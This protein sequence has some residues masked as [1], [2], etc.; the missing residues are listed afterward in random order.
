M[1]RITMEVEI[2]VSLEYLKEYAD[3]LSALTESV[4]K[5]TQQGNYRAAISALPE[6]EKR[7]AAVETEYR[8]LA[9]ALTDG[10]DNIDMW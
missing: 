10:Q 2:D 9:K 7:K 8:R 4:Q 3:K 5:H 6:L 1:D